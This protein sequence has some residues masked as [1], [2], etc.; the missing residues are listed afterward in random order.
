MMIRVVA[1]EVERRGPIKTY[2]RNIIVGETFGA[3]RKST[4]CEPTCHLSARALTLGRSHACSAL[5]CVLTCKQGAH[6]S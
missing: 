3:G 2:C 5:V 4:G 6:V 1:E